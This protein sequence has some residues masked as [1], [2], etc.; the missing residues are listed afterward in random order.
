MS[1]LLTRRSALIG[2]FTS[3]I[4]PPA[5]VALDQAQAADP[6]EEAADLAFALHDRLENMPTGRW[7]WTQVGPGIGCGNAMQFWERSGSGFH[8]AERRA[9]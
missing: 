3:L 6:W 2:G 4:I 8:R 5:A 7:W 9:A 1:F